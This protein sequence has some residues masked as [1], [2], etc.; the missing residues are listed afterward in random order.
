MDTK[1]DTS[2]SKDEMAHVLKEQLVSPQAAISAPTGLFDIIPLSSPKSDP[3]ALSSIWGY[4]EKMAES[5]AHDYGF[6]EIRTPMF[7]KVELFQRGVGDVTDI[8]SKEM[9]VFEDRGGRHLA[10]RPEGTASV[11]RALIEHQLFS[12]IHDLRLFYIGPM[13]RYERPQ[14]GRYRQHH[15][16]GVEV[17]GVQGFEQDAEI[18]EMLYTFYTRLQ[19]PDLTVSINS[20]GSK[21]AREKFRAALID[22]LRPLAHLLSE[23]SAIRLVKNPLRILDSKDPRDKEIVAK[24]PSIFEFL[25][26][27][28][29]A[30]FEGVL[31]LLQM[32]KIPYVI[33][34]TLVRGLDYYQKTVFEVTTGAL[35]AQNTIGAGGRY[36]G[37]LK[38]MGGPD[39]PSI[40]FATGLERVIQTMLQVHKDVENQKREYSFKEMVDLIIIPIGNEAMKRAVLIAHD[41]RKEHR[42]VLVDMTQKKLKNA[43]AGASQSGARSVM[44]LGDTEL[45]VGKAKIRWLETGHEEEVSLQS[46]DEIVRKIAASL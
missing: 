40:G 10:L 9:Y 26:V 15:Q 17:V 29:R 25:S 27:E 35:G 36:D 28:D 1:R 7:E 41:L 31:S 32:M 37:L 11:M 12:P 5:L 45:E 6:H 19:I 8:V 30:H 4:V 42:R 18:I 3:W 44:I 24:A 39:L 14:A 21:E 22:Y 46:I 16:F 20:L 23:E 34:P 43:M 33:E 2:R 13:F 38:Q